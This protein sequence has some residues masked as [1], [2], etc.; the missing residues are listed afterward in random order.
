MVADPS[1][2]RWSS[3]NNRMD[4]GDSARWLDTDPCYPALGNTA[5]QR[6]ERYRT[7]VHG[8]VSQAELS[9]IREGLQRGQLTGDSRFVDEVER[10]AGLRIERRGRGR[11]A[12]TGK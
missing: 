1:D 7:F 11:P 2:Y 3:Y 9:L 12:C 5:Q 6:S 10:I 4:A 8:A